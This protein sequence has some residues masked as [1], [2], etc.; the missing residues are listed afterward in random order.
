MI[1]RLDP[2][3]DPKEHDHASFVDMIKAMDKVVEVRKGDSDHQL[4]LR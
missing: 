4:R 3:F 2:T 1:K